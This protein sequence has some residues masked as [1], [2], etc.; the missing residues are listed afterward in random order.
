MSQQVGGAKK[1]NPVPIKLLTN[2]NETRQSR[3]N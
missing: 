1:F 3:I 2:I